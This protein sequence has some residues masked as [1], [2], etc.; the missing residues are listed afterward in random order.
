MGK[1]GLLCLFW[2]CAIGAGVCFG[3]GIGNIVSVGAGFIVG[4]VCCIIIIPYG[5]EFN[6]KFVKNE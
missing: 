3:I 6:N 1:E 5:I 4:G 2:F